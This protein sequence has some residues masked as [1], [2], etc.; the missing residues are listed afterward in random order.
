VS[1]HQG[2]TASIAKENAIDAGILRERSEIEKEIKLRH[3]KW[4]EGG[5]DDPPPG[6]ETSKPQK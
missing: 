1:R 6:S 5:S 2:F 3:D 4:R